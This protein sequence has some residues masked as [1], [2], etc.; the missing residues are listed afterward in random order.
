MD[1]KNDPPALIP[2][3]LA[4]PK[5]RKRL[6]VK[7][8]LLGAV[9][10]LI[11]AAALVIIAEWQSGQYNQLAQREV[12]L[13]IDADLD[14]ITQ[15][16]YNLVRTENE[17]VQAQINYNLNVA[18]HVLVGAGDV[19]LSKDIINWTAVNQFS[20]RA[21]EI[22]LP[23]FLVGNTWLEKNTNLAM[24]TPIVDVVTR[25]VGETAT[26]FQ[27]I[28]EQGDMLRVATTVKAATGQRATG[29]YIP[30]VNPDN[31][32]NPV[33][34]AILKGETY[35]GRAY[36]VNDWYLTAYEP[37]YDRNGILLGMLNVGIKQ[38]MAENR[39]RQAILKTKVGKTGYV[40][41]LAGGGKNRGQYIISNKGERDGENVWNNRDSDGR[42]V[43]QE[44]INKA[45]V[46]EPEGMTTV[47]YRWQNPGEK[48]PRLKIAR[49]TYYEPWDWVI[50]TS[51]YEDELN[52]YR[53]LL[54]D[55]RRA[56]SQAMVS[57]GLAIT[58]LVGFAGF[59]IAWTITRPVRR[60]TK[61]VKKIIGGDLNQTVQVS[62]QDEIGVLAQTFNLMARK[63]LHSIQELKENEGKY[64]DIF[65]NALEGLFRVTLDGRFL[66]ANPALA[67]ILG[68]ASAEELVTAVTDL[69]QQLYVSPQDRDKMLRVLQT[70]GSIVG[71][72]FQCRKKDEN[73]IWVSIS[74]LL[75]KDAGGNPI[76][77]DGFLMDINARKHAE[78]ALAESMNYLDEIINAVADPI[79]V[80]DRQHVWVLVNDAMCTFSGHSRE[81]LL[82]KTDYDCF[83]KEEADIF[84][85]KDEQ[86]FN[87][88]KES[89]NEEM[90]TDAYGVVHTIVTRKTL[91]IDKNGQS[92]IVGIIRDI[93]NQK[94][95]E[96]EKNVL[97]MRLTQAQKMEAIGTL[98]G[99]IAH[100]FNNILSAIIGYGELVREDLSK[101]SE[102]LGYVDEIIRAGNRARELVKQIL[103]FS[104]MTETEYSP[105]AIRSIIKE[106]M[107][108]LRS[109][110]PS[111]IKIVQN[112]SVPGLVMSDPTQI[113]QI[114]MNLC[115][116]AVHAMD[117]T[118]GTLGIFLNE[119][120][121]DD[122]EQIKKLGIE[123]GHYMALTISDTG[124]GIPTEIKERMFEPYFTTKEAGRGTG[125]G[126]SVLHGIVKSHNGAITCD[127]TL[128]QG[129]TFVVYL[130]KLPSSQEMGIAPLEL[131]ALGGN[132]RIL[133]VDDEYILTVMA[134]KML[135]S[136][137]YKVVS[138]TSSS[139]A[140][141]L[142]KKN[143]QAFDLVI[144]DMTM[145]G[146]TG[147]RMAQEML[148]VRPNL[149]IILCTGYNEHITEEKAKSIGIRDFIFKPLNMH[150][151]TKA[152]RNIFDGGD[153]G[154]ADEGRNCQ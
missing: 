127:S 1:K 40:Y 46:L 130:P 50:G 67:R 63:L 36:V 17:A 19:H 153:G 9:S 110:I 78:A 61:G 31:T 115:T 132:E 117:E 7:I 48:K 89:I 142:F 12:S 23:K 125:L 25:L 86:V 133:F 70:R 81:A 107:G 82:G 32:A 38:E 59:I 131:P 57:A 10:V 58:L 15:G 20:G 95:T 93:T 134:T 30:A 28:N 87:S 66:N 84:W 148:A 37:I 53:S 145:P 98:A 102:T 14:H 64:R 26:I 39:V 11:T 139:D 101:G 112:F 123:P 3:N 91:Y 149:P 119:V 135:S 121:L 103:T 22:S 55:G 80:K 33:I 147:D 106:S 45:I 111:T 94:R 35:H 34:A 154:C 114:L 49:L 2:N 150:A 97:E 51:V 21:D 85:K 43:I 129:T 8:A 56:M 128:G 124:T 62:S 100:D 146:M 116:N 137:G 79:F 151:M 54:I 104:R 138:E 92:L 108:M 47:R 60:M 77:I 65:E 122:P 69:K 44:I 75:V 140:L 68:Y 143:S 24:E 52:A 120:V 4:A 5:R 105:I 13:L 88:G 42:Y 76:H 27:R 109:V 74:A 6:D 41:V 18:R 152:I 96:E 71:W 144:T 29:T 118:G 99:G 83:P 126:L 72:E 73:I 16:I 113:N 90:V 136:K 141:A